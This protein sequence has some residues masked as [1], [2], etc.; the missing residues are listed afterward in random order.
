MNPT[1]LLH[2]AHRTEAYRAHVS[3]LEGTVAV[4]HLVALPTPFD[5]LL[6]ELSHHSVAQS[7]NLY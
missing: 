1:F 4:K 7:L 5:P 2:P 6:S 3:I